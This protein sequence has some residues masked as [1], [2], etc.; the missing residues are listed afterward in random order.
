MANRIN[1]DHCFICGNQHTPATPCPTH[2][3]QPEPMDFSGSN[4]LVALAAAERWEFPEGDPDILAALHQTT[5]IAF[6]SAYVLRAFDE[7]VL[8]GFQK[9][10]DAMTDREILR[11]FKIAWDRYGM[12]RTREDAPVPVNAKPR[13]A[14]HVIDLS[15][16]TD[17]EREQY[18]AKVQASRSQ[19]GNVV[20]MGKG[21]GEE[22]QIGDTTYKP[23]DDPRLSAPV[24]AVPQDG[25]KVRGYR[26]LSEFEIDKMNT[27]K[28][29]TRNLVDEIDTYTQQ[30]NDDLNGPAMMSAAQAAELRTALGWLAEA[31]KAAQKACM[32]A[33]RAAAKPEDDC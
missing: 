6:A 19:A 11:Q 21:E 5:G 10:I 29:A 16:L 26:K 7:G 3:N 9:P 18:R 30:I 25:S 17:E 8:E 13:D 14:A 12:I 4:P 31:R 2:T 20:Y 28:A 22:F 33:C 15:N 24:A 32:F 27:F 1:S 23:E